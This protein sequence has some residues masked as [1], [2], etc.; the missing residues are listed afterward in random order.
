VPIIWRIMEAVIAKLIAW[1]GLL[2]LGLIVGG[3]A[4]SSERGPSVGSAVSTAPSTVASTVSTM[5][6]P[7]A[8]WRVFR[9]DAGGYRLRYPPGW[10]A[11][12][13]TGSG[14]PVLSLLP[15]KGTGISV[16]V[17]LTPP[18]E[19]AAA[20][21]PNTRCRSVRI[22]GLTGSRCLDTISM[23]VTTTLQGRERWYVLTTSLRR[24]AAPVDAYDQVL[25]SFRLT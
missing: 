18:P 20:N 24:P 9:S 23:V 22:G 11:K 19:A 12:E 10:R 17:T 15:P 1:A 25:G 5:P 21:L 8:N 13:S 14:G 16:L 3:C 7:V 6:A 4:R 2:V